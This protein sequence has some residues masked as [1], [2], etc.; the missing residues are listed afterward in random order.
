MEF[1]AT[2]C[3]LSIHTY[4]ANLRL[5]VSHMLRALAI[6]CQVASGIDG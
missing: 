1:Y 2:V 5:N 6:T 4:I 3:H